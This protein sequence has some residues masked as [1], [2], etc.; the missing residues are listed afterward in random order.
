[1]VLAGRHDPEELSRFRIEAEAAA[2][3]QHPNIVQ[4]YEHG[5]SNGE[6]YFSLEFVEGGS[7]DKKLA[8]TPQPPQEAA[9]IVIMLA[10]ALQ[11]AHEKGIIHRDLKP[12]NVLVAADGTLKISDFGLA[13]RLDDDSGRT[14]SGAIIGTPSYMAP[15]Q[16][17]GNIKA[18]GPLVDVY[19]AGR[20]LRDLNGPPAFPRYHALGDGGAGPHAGT[21]VA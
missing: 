11:Y 3:L 21:G 18:L 17:F 1:M 9:R 16:A 19:A 6:P 2:C 8:A 7:L 10:R 12:G 13:K 15:E 5:E 14:R 4:V 20:S